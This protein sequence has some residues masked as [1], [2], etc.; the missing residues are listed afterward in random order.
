MKEII[1]IQAGQCGNQISSTFWDHLNVEHKNLEGNHAK[2]FYESLNGLTNR[3]ILLDS[4]PRAIEQIFNGNFS[5]EN[6]LISEEKIGSGNNW[7]IGR[8]TASKMENKIKDLIQRELEACESLEGFNLMHSTAGGT[9]S[10]F[11]S[12]LVKILKENYAKKIISTI[13]VLP[14]NEISETVV[15]PY[16]SVLNLAAILESDNPILVDNSS[17]F[18]IGADSNDFSNANFLLGSAIASYTRPL[19]FP[20]FMFSDLSEISSALNIGRLNLKTFSCNFKNK[21]KT[22]SFEILKKLQNRNN[23][24]ADFSTSTENNLCTKNE[25]ISCINFVFNTKNE[26]LRKS[27]LEFFEKGQSQFV[28]WMP[29]SYFSLGLEYENEL[30]P[31]DAV[32]ITNSTGITNLISNVCNQFDKLKKRGAF[33][34]VYRKYDENLEELENSRIKLQKIVEE[35]ENASKTF[36]D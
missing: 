21:R 36:A 12:F 23:L 4:E 17:L 22:K 6:V 13:S 18:R 15:Q 32:G 5:E 11:S 31:F 8:E 14:S 20:S 34:D 35:Y 3:A 16:N 10:G 27:N 33:L 28:K 30:N 9:G 26:D 29:P 7:A 2:F 19:R 1:T 24:F 25:I